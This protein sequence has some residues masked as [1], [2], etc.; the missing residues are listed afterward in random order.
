[1]KPLIIII[2]LLSACLEASS[3][4]SLK[5]DKVVELDSSYN[6]EKI[7]S[8]IVLALGEIFPNH[9]QNMVSTE[10][11]I[12]RSINLEFDAGG[13]RLGSNLFSGAISF[14]L[15]F[16][17]KDGRY[18]Y[19][20]SDAYHKSNPRNNCKPCDMGLITVSDT[21]PSNFGASKSLAKE[22]WNNAQKDLLIVSNKIEETINLK[23]SNLEW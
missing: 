4:E 18:R 2:Y 15:Q 22:V 21:P 14:T 13:S 7:K 11:I 9:Q 8:S 20:I 23:L 10:T 6:I 16:M 1:M 12:T 19:L 5:I 17:I 3:Q